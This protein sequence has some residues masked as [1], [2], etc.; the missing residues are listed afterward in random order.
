[1]G[2][3][4]EFVYVLTLGVELLVELNNQYGQCE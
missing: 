3:C 4:D 1:M 2:T